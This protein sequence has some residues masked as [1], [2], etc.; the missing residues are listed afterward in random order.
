MSQMVHGNAAG[1]CCKLCW[2]ADAVVGCRQLS[3]LEKKMSAD[4]YMILEQTCNIVKVTGCVGMTYTFP[5]AFFSHA[6]NLILVYVFYSQYRK[7][8]KNFSRALGEDGE[9]CADLSVFRRR[10]QTLSRAVSKMDG[11]MKFNEFLSFLSSHKFNA[12]NHFVPL[13]SYSL[14]HFM[15]FNNVGGLCFLGCVVTVQTIAI[16]IVQQSDAYLSDGIGIH[17]APRLMLWSL[18]SSLCARRQFLKFVR[19]L[20][21][22]TKL[23]NVGGFVFHIVNIFG[24]FYHFPIQF[25]HSDFRLSS[26]ALHLLSNGP[27]FPSSTSSWSSTSSYSI[28]TWSL[29]RCPRLSTSS[30][31][32]WTSKACSWQSA[33]AS[34]SI[35]W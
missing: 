4:I 25:S 7:M 32:R 34:S 11:F 26:P 2:V 21:S 8:K 3:R 33:T 12:F 35:T 6:M 18:S 14:T 1:Q 17:C 9:F 20:S 19:Q 30:G 10:H 29:T 24:T 23:T 22:F 15:K 28:R 5:T 13:R 16:H 27:C 31:W